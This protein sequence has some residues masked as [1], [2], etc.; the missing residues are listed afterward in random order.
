MKKVWENTEWIADLRQYGLLHILASHNTNCVDYHKL[1]IVDKKRKLN[2]LQKM[3]EGMNIKLSS[4]AANI[5]DCLQCRR[6]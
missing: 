1:S 5:G 2:R 3:L 6:R 4:S